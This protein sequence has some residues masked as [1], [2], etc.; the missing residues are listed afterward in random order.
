MCPPHG[1]LW[2]SLPWPHVHSKRP[3]ERS[4]GLGSGR[5][6]LRPGRIAHHRGPAA[7]L[8][9][10]AEGF[11]GESNTGGRRNGKPRKVKTMI[12]SPSNGVRQG[13]YTKSL[14]RNPG[15]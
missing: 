7:L 3:L 12:L 13:L 4:A 15:A 10:K 11:C 1:R 6:S 5:V 2:E 8:L 9:V 14:G